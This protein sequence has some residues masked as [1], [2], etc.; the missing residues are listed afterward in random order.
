MFFK[1]DT[2]TIWQIKTTFSCALFK[3]QPDITYKDKPKYKVHP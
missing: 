2:L 1:I 3:T